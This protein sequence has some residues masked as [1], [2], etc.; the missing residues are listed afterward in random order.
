MFMHTRQMALACGLAMSITTAGAAMAQQEQPRPSQPTTTRPVQPITT[1]SQPDRTTDRT[2]T[3]TGA[4]PQ[5]LR[6]LEGV[7][8][9]EV[10]VNPEFWELKHSGPPGLKR[11]G[12]MDRDRDD[13][14]TPGADR[15]G[16]TNKLNQPGQPDRPGQPTDPD[17]PDRVKD[18][19]KRDTSPTGTQPG[20]TDA[21]TFIGYAE[22]RLVLGNHILQQSIVVPDM[23]HSGAGRTAPNLNAP[24]EIPTTTTGDMFRG[25]SFL[26]FDEG[27]KEYT[28]VFMDSRRGQ[29]HCDRGNYDES[30]RKLVFEGKGHMDSGKMDRDNVRVVLEVLNSTQH[31]VTMYK[32][33]AGKLTPGINQP[34]RINQPDATRPGQ[35]GRTDQPDAGRPGQPDRILQPENRPGQPDLSGSEGTII[36]QATYT[37]AQSSDAPKFRRLIQEPRTPA[38]DRDDR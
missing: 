30:N 21:K 13:K 11:D 12:E 38:M 14:T 7:W 2:L 27:S 17:N 4:A 37:K 19:F 8:R 28:A 23:Q 36:Y 20:L 29:I 25:M 1:P 24:N 32:A 15:P 34:N 18:P 35:P 26:A 5:L 31:R 33:D 3:T 10:K 22:T 9:V 6:D 16:D